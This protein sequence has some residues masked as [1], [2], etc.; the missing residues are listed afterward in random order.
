MTH[1]WVMDNNCVKYPDSG[2]KKLWP[3]HDV[4]R[5]TDRQTYNITST[6]RRPNLAKYQISPMHKF[7]LL[8]VIFLRVNFFKKKIRHFEKF[9]T[10]DKP[11]ILRTTIETSALA[12]F[13]T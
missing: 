7:R 2:S 13:G 9:Q 11:E 3:G 1:P 5:W 6:G 10:L 8:I 4:N 12:R